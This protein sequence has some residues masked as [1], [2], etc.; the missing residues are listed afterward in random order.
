MELKKLTPNLMVF[1]VNSTVEF[2]RDIL[3]FELVMTVPEKGLFDWAMVRLGAVEIM[4]QSRSSLSQEIPI[5]NIRETGGSLTFYIEM[6][7]LDELY[8]G[9]KSKLPIVY[10]LHKTFYGMREFSIKD[11]NGYI[12]TFAEKSPE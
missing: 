9:I 12:L 6:A 11:I 1:N 3:G 4:F 5:M 7:G 8:A 10:D 2:Y